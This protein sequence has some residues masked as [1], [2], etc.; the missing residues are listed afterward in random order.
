MKNILQILFTGSLVL[1]TLVARAQ[2]LKSWQY[3]VPIAITNS[4]SG[5]LTNYQVK[6]YVNTAVPTLAGKMSPTCDDVR[7]TDTFCN[8]L[9][10]WIENGINTDSTLIWVKV[11][12]IPTTGTA[13]K[14]YYG[15]PSLLTTSNGDSTFIFFDNFQGKDLDTN[16]W[17][18]FHSGSAS[19]TVSSGALTISS[20]LDGA[21][22]SKASFPSPI[23]LESNIISANV[24]AGYAH[25]I[26]LLRSDSASGVALT[27]GNYH[28]AYCM[29]LGSADQ[30]NATY[31]CS[32]QNVNI[33]PG[34][35]TGLWS[36]SW[37]S[38]GV[39]YSSW[40]GGNLTGAISS[41]MPTANLRVGAGI[42]YSG[43]GSFVTNMIR[44]RKY[45]K[46]EPT[47]SVGTESTNGTGT[48]IKVTNA[49]S[50]AIKIFPNPANDIV[51]IDLDASH[52]GFH[53][54]T[55]TDMAGKLLYS[56][57]LNNLDPNLQLQTNDY[58]KGIYLIKLTGVNQTFTQKLVIE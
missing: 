13:I 40:P 47:D 43:G 45:S 58:P 10:F 56:R 28:G 33:N 39:Q 24:T 44:V 48:G 27:Y 16:K 6:I 55:M 35:I 7:F 20:D 51:N 32:N 57:E 23:V 53:T 21:I 2:C 41:H 29:L 30:A 14:M 54:L 11:P 15:N 18:I 36:L 34:T 50:T 26:A 25:H 5:T 42:L 17:Q 46:I 22:R 38:S 4:T 37:P 49:E 9:P 1:A 19:F 52:T 12:T 3:F 31:G 8:N